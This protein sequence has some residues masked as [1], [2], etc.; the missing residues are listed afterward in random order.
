MCIVE[1]AIVP[2]EVF[3]PNAITFHLLEH[4]TNQIEVIDDARLKSDTLFRKNNLQSISLEKCQIESYF[5][6]YAFISYCNKVARANA[7]TNEFSNE[8]TFTMKFKT[9]LCESKSKLYE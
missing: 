7:S 5:K 8:E 4:M 9:K 3:I 2:K 6:R 1:K